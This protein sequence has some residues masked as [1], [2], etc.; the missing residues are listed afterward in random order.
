MSF[1]ILTTGYYNMNKYEP[2]GLVSS[3]PVHSIS[4]IRGL[5]SGITGFFGGRQQVIEKK[6]LDIRKEAL[7][8]LEQEAKAMGAVMIIGLEFNVSELGN[9]FV[10]YGASGTALKLKSGGSVMKG[11]IKK[12]LKKDNKSK[13]ESKIKKDKI[14]KKKSM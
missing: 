5:V 14:N 7:Y 13:K 12:E 9:E 6:F 2:I 1:P 8:E 11:G 3:I 4:A 10:I